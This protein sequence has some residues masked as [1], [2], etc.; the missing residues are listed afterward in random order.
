[1]LVVKPESG[2]VLLR[3]I[4]TTDDCQFT[5]SKNMERLRK[6]L[7]GKARQCVKIM[8]L[9][10]NAGRVIEILR[11]NYGNS[12]VILNQLIEEVQQQCPVTKSRHF[13]CQ[14]T[15]CN[16]MRQNFYITKLRSTIKKIFYQ[17]GYCRKVKSGPKLPQM[18]NLP[19]L[20]YGV[21]ETFCLYRSRLF[22]TNV[23][24]N[25]KKTIKSL[26]SVVY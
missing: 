24:G 21:Y 19:D 5:E 14:E 4:R 7:E 23:R 20:I 17:C 2:L 1:M 10:N 16:Q 3:L 13:Q 15:L 26:G 11:S 6:S 25:S 18:G 8:L 12:D 9:T 22:W